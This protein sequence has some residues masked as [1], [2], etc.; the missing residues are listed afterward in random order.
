MNQRE[1]VLIAACQ[2]P[3]QDDE[4]FQSSLN[5]LV[6]LTETAH[7][8]VV[9]IVTQKR[10]RIHQAYYIGT[11]KVEEMNVYIE[12][13][14]IDL[15]I[16]NDELTPSQMN[17]LADFLEVRIIDRT[18]LILDIFASRANTR[19]GKLQVE[20]A[21]MSYLLPRLHGQGK[22]LSR[23]GGGIGTRGPGETKLESDRRH[24][25]RRMDDIKRQM[26]QVAKQR[27]QYRK[28]R[29]ENQ[30]F[31]IAI[32]GYTNAGK[33]TLFN[34]MTDSESFEENQLFATLDPLTRQVQ[35]T[36]GFHVLMSDTVG[37]IQDLP[38]AL[39]AAFRSTLE[40]VTEADFILHVVDA[41]HPDHAEHEKT[42]QKHLEQLEAHHIPMLTVYNK[43]D[44][45]TE[46]FVPVSVP[47]ITI[48]AYQM[49][50]IHRLFKRIEEVILKQFV[51]YQLYVKPSEADYLHRLSRQSIVTEQTFLE[52]QELYIVKGYIHT[53]HPMYYQMRIDN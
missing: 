2:L 39:I 21:Q 38:T 37:F 9:S 7:G 48:S 6:S 31:Q 40:E 20:L 35:L 28:R 10:Q 27:L 1:R 45:V 12:Q 36:S 34:R 4:R 51:A 46:T 5:E 26:E 13:E 50:D 14:Q 24:I 16:F 17:H 47:H 29:K 15:V 25:L 8:E 18:Q 30:A 49:D 19:E 52:E 11:G 41:S 44:L 53:E 22:N 33:S 23:L 3:N 32:V 43:M 42:V